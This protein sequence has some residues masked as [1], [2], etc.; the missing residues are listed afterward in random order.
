MTPPGQ[1]PTPFSHLIH[2][3]PDPADR[4]ATAG[5]GRR[6]RAAVTAPRRGRRVARRVLGVVTAVVVLAAGAGVYGY[7]RLNE[8]VKFSV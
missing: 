5:T 1:A 2:A 4:S 6:T 3:G 7:S 8:L